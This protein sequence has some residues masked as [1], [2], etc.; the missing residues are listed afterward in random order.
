MFTGLVQ[1]QGS[2]QSAEKQKYGVKFIVQ[3][4]VDQ[5]HPQPRH[6]DSVAVNGC[7]LTH[8]GDN[9]TPAGTLIFH[10][11][12]ETL[13]KTSL[14]ELQSGD[15]VNLEPAV[16]ANTPMG[17]HFVQGH[18]DGCGE[19]IV[20]QDDAEDWRMTI[21]TPQV[22]T[23]YIIPKGSI[24]IQGVSLTIAACDP[25]QDTFEVALIPTTL[26]ITTLGQLKV[27]DPVNLEGDMI[28][29]SVVHFLKNQF[30]GGAESLTQLIE[31]FRQ[32]DE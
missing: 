3:Y 30:A 2:I 5:L 13:N 1:C 28:V 12:Q 19:V 27:G 20:I 23:P 22:L 29:K 6:G 11:I 14:G 4:P 17:G 9:D 15:K 18:V 21:K 26:E 24:C 8:T 7:C 25:K 32:S 10:V 31:Q 16:T